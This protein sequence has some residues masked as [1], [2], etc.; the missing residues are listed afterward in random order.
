MKNTTWQ[1]VEPGQIVKFSYKSMNSKRGEQRVILIIDPKYRYKK[2]STNRIVEYVVGLQ[3]DTAL[4]PP[5]NVR[6]FNKLISLYDGLSIDEGIIEVGEQQDI[7]DK[8]VAEKV[9]KKLKRFLKTNDIFRTFFLRECKKRRVFL[10]DSYQGFPRKAKEDIEMRRM[11]EETIKKT[12]D[13]Q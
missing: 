9:Y 4:R 13:L 1:R 2:K 6:S 7:A 5:I 12:R 11:I 10:L 3:L 8:D